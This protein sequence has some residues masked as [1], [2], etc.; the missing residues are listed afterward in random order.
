MADIDGALAAIG[1]AAIAAASPENLG[2][3]DLSSAD[4]Q[5]V[6]AGLGLAK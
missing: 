3:L 1:G 6:G 4:I 5:N 2:P